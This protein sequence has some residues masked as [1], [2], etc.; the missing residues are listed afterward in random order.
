MRNNAAVA[1]AVV[2]SIMC[3]WTW[4]QPAPWGCGPRS[5]GARSCTIIVK[6][7]KVGPPCTLKVEDAQGNDQTIVAVHANKTAVV[8][9]KWSLDNV[10]LPPNKYRFST[11]SPVALKPG[12]PDDGTFDNP[13]AGA[14]QFTM[15]D[16]VNN[17]AYDYALTVFDKI[18]KVTC[19]LDPTIANQGLEPLVKGQ[20]QKK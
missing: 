5:T 19:T 15:T 13:V 20:T 8:P 7:D 11:L 2:L 17:A 12:T 6:L 14:R 4:A 9:I 1:S 18:N 16:R 3:D 10:T